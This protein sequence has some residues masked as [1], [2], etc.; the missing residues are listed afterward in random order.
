MYDST[1]TGNTA[2]NTATTAAPDAC[3]AERCVRRVVEELAMLVARLHQR[4]DLGHGEVGAAGGAHVHHRRDRV[5]RARDTGSE[6]QV[7]CGG[8][9]AREAS[10]REKRHPWLS[11]ST[12]PSSAR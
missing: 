7:G 4:L 2:A 9:R 10:S 5:E 3:E 11:A 8:A 12:S 1:R 6:I